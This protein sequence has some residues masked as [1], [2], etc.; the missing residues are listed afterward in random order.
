MSQ[1]QFKVRSNMHAGMIRKPLAPYHPN[2]YR[3]RLPSPTIVMPY[4]NS[5]QIVIGDRSAY[6]K[7]QFSTTHGNT[8]IKPISNISA[9][10]G[11]QADSTK[12]NHVQRDSWRGVANI[13]S[14]D[15]VY[16]I[17]RELKEVRIPACVPLMCW[18]SYIWLWNKIDGQDMKMTMSE[19]TS[20]LPHC[21][22]L[23]V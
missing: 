3:S 14:Q 18:A 8:F 19:H 7:K 4:K 17:K 23:Q 20:L 13:N 1:D 15:P 2:A 22:W 5:S 11:I 6:Y 21:L 10:P 16:M 12:R 9:N